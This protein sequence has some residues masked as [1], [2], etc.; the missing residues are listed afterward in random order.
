MVIEVKNEG[1]GKKRFIEVKYDIGWCKVV[2]GGE[3]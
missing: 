1:A 3:T 2:C